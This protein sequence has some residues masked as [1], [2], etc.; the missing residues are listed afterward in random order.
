M[1]KSLSILVGLLL[2]FMLA[3]CNQTA[4]PVNNATDS[5]KEAS[6]EKQSEL[7]LEEVL[8]KS[9]AASESLKSFSVKM[10][11]DQKISS[12]VEEMNMDMKSVIDM[13]VVMDPMAFYQK[14]TMTIGEEKVEM[15]SYF[16]EDG[17]FFYEPSGGQWMKFP[18]EMTDMF[19]QMTGEQ[20]N[21]GDELKK[22]Q[23]FV[24]DF[25]FEQDDKNFI[26]KL[27]AEGEKFNQFIKETAMESLPAD[28]AQEELLD[29]MNIKSVDYEIVIDKETFNPVSLI[30][31][32]DMDMTVEGETINLKQ[33]VN[34]QYLNLNNIDVI[35]VPQEVIDSA[36]DIDM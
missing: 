10:D 16:S 28:L 36:V 35:T 24:D 29:Q 13:D 21:P 34:A 6:K 26:L 5:N 14:M 25:T 33:K 1:K 8:E 3:A 30:V 32:M 17:M 23:R 18:Q 22:L 15:E 7:T 11:M 20:Q 19:L 12:S 9:T 4:T 27:K 31:D 2:V